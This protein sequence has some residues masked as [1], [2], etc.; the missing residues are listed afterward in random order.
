VNPVVAAVSTF[1]YYSPRLPQ[2][3]ALA[4]ALAIPARKAKLSREYRVILTL[5]FSQRS[6]NHEGTKDTKTKEFEI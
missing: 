6:F 4:R 3:Q 2:P 1:R 5:E